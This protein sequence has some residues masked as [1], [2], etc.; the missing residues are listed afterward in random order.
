[1]SIGSLARTLASDRRLADEVSERPTPPERGPHGED[2][3]ADRSSKAASSSPL[4]T[5]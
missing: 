1:M 5:L 2:H 4:A 3:P